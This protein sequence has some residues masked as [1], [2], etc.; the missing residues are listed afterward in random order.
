MKVNQ[1][2]N[3]NTLKSLSYSDNSE[4]HR[5]LYHPW[6]AM[7]TSYPGTVNCITILLDVVVP[8]HNP[9]TGESEARELGVLG[10][11]GPQSETLPQKKKTSNQPTKQKHWRTS[12]VCVCVCVCVVLGFWTQGLVHATQA[13]KHL[14]HTPSTFHF[15]YF[16]GRVS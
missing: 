13:L 5:H 11:S 3:L 2:W 12:R 4:K 7:G 10:Q 15:S 8:I 1:N 14:S 6:S 16:L 9:N